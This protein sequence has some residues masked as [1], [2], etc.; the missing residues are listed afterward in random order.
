MTFNPECNETG[1][2]A[3]QP[4]GGPP[5]TLTDLTSTSNGDRYAVG[6]NQSGWVIGKFL[7]TGAP[8]H[9]FGHQGYVTFAEQSAFGSGNGRAYAVSATNSGDVFVLGSDAGGAKSKSLLM[10]LTSHGSLDKAFGHGGVIATALPLGAENLTMARTDGGELLVGGSATP[11]ESTTC[12]IFHI[13]EYQPTGAPA[14]EFRPIIGYGDGAKSTSC[15][16]GN[17][18]IPQFDSAKLT[19]I[20]TLPSG[21][22]IAVGVGSGQDPT[23]SG[24]FMCWHEADGDLDADVGSNESGVSDVSGRT[25]LERT[26]RRRGRTGRR[27][28][29]RDVQLAW[30]LA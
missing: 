14:R 28:R 4:P 7:P 18:Q 1:G 5:A 25:G 23:Q 26:D 13:R 8:A 20:V 24:G 21:G 15:R 3:F 16:E 29:C 19:S 11:D 17:A 12:M 6:F 30:R 22:F 27:I 10:A 9:N 2:Y